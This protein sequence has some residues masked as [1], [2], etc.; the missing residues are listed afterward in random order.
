VAGGARW[1]SWEEVELESLDGLYQDV[2]DAC[3]IIN[4]NKNIEFRFL[5]FRQ[6]SISQKSS[7][8]NKLSNNC[9]NTQAFS[10]DLQ[11]TEKQILYIALLQCKD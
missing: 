4:T 3:D 8:F 11:N 10:S 6:H 2:K 9:F 5:D 1:S 7:F